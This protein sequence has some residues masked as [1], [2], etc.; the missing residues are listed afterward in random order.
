MSDEARLEAILAQMPY[1][2]RLGVIPRLA[3]GELVVE[4]PYAVAL[5]GNPR[6]PALHG[7]AVGA[8]LE[9]AAQMRLRLERDAHKPPVPIGVTIEYLR[10]C[11]T[12]PTFAKA[13][14]KRLGRRIA[15][16][17]AECWQ[18]EA[19]TPLALLQGRFL[20]GD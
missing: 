1:A 13:E 9:I 3:E 19:R 15:N 7:G 17:H 6:L 11:R 2:R 8:F 5:L 18:D 16:I 20:M 10:P 14:V 12:R 4:M